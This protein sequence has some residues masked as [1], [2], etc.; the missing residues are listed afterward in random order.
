M[1]TELEKEIE[2]YAKVA[3]AYGNKKSYICGAVS[4][5]GYDKAKE[6][7]KE[8]SDLVQKYGMIPSSTFTG[9]Q[10]KNRTKK[11]YERNGVRELMGCDVLIAMSNWEVS[12]GAQKQIKIAKI[13]NIPVLYLSSE[14]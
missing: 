6:K 1:K 9:L 13:M 14:K 7:F 5:I 10:P 8:V 11:I 4:S 3:L 12:D 2:I